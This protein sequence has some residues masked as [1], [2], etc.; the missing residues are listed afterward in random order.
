MFKSIKKLV[1]AIFI[2]SCMLVLFTPVAFADEVVNPGIINQIEKC[3]DSVEKEIAKAIEQAEKEALKNQSEEKLN[4]S[5]DKII[6]KLL[7]KTEKSVDKVMEKAANEGITLTKVYIPVQI[8]DRTV[9][10][11]PLFVY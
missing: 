1:S 10:V 5:L 7:E 8:L 2:M 3:N 11:D 6:E 9:Y 4:A